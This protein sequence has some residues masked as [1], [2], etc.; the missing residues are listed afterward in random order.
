MN[1]TEKSITIFNENGL[2]KEITDQGR[3]FK[4]INKDLKL[5]L[6]EDKTVESPMEQITRLTKE[7][8]LDKK[9]K[10]KKYEEK[11]KK[12]KDKYRKIKEE[13]RLLKIENQK[14]KIRKYE[15]STTETN[16]EESEIEK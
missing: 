14:L 16:K 4:V 3:I 5:F 12:Y 11:Y 9:T 1:K 10:D 6:K 13:I 7:N 15:S 2:T 8:K